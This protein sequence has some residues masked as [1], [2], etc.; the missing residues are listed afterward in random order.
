MEKNTFATSVFVQTH[1]TRAFE[2]LRRLENLNEWTLGSRM[3]ARIDDDTW[4]GTASGYQSMLCYHVRTLEHPV[5]RAIEWQCGY[6]YDEYF[7]QYPV[8]LLP[9]D[10]LDPMS[11]EQGTYLHWVSV[12]DPARRTPM[13]ME[14]IQAVHR[15]EARAL[16]AALERRE[17]LSQAAHGRFRVETDTIYIDASMELASEYVAD[18]RTLPEW[19]PL[20]RPEGE[21]ACEQGRFRDEYDRPV[22]VSF[23]AHRLSDYAL[24][25]QDYHDAQSGFLQRCPVLLI[26]SERA[27]GAGAR[28]VLLHRLTFWDPRRPAEHGRLQIEDFG[29][30]SMA[31]K[32]RLEAKAGH[33]DSF[34]RGMS[35]APLDPAPVASENAGGTPPDVFSPEFVRDPYPLYRIMRDQHPL[36]FHPQAQAWILSRYQ[37]VHVALTDPVFTTRSYAAQTEPL[38][39]KTIIQ[40]DGRE[41]SIQRNLLQP[42]FRAG[43]IQTRFVPLIERTVRELVDGFRW[44]DGADLMADFVTQ[45]PVR[46]MAGILGLPATDLDRFRAWY[47]ALI[48]GALNLTRDPDVARAAEHARDQLDAYL[49]PLIRERRSSPKDDLLSQLATAEIEGTRLSDDEITR[50]GMLLVFAA[51]ETTEKALATTLRNL[52]AHPVQLERVRADRSLLPQAIAESFRF[53]APTHMVPRKTCAIVKVSGGTLPAEAEVMCF[54]GAANRDER[55]FTRADEFDIFRAENE[56]ERA[57][58]GQTAHLAFGAGRHFCLGAIL[59]KIELEIA[60]NQLL[61]AFPRLRFV[62]DVVPP[63]VGLFLRCPAALP[64]SFT[65]SRQGAMDLGTASPR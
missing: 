56:G 46:I 55:R 15:F 31:L 48:H 1:P 32:R 44:R 29:A 38:L 35:Y 8:L 13:I 17:G 62:D 43:S 2:Y 60:I 33:L 19:S 26:P 4:M 57:P 22:S 27:F 28:G 47:S 42:S 49:R 7:K 41:H 20:F 11:E 64:V 6:R 5:F 30:E 16:K 54:L 50:F 39:G 34:A 14:G 59:S 12:I 25:E 40:L 51:G 45:F 36:Y 3:V 63:D 37:D 23:R 52:I 10:Y 61:D 18:V 24:V 53:T 21:P 9:P 58:T 65:E